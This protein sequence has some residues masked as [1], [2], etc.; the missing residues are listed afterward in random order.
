MSLSLERI[1]GKDLP[2]MQPLP[3]TFIQFACGANQINTDVPRADRNSLFT[4]YLL[5]YIAEPNIPI[6][7]IFNNIEDAVYQNSNQ[8]QRPLSMNGLEQY[9]QL[10]LN[11]TIIGT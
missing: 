4:K 11:K 9:K 2:S 6:V 8:R 5:Q 1:E 10:C 7:N 3:E